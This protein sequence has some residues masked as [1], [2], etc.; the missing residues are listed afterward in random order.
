MKVYIMTDLEG[1]SGA[2][3]DQFMDRSLPWYRDACRFLMGDVNAAIAGAFDGGATEVWARDGHG[4][5]HNFIMDLLDP[6]AIHEQ[7]Y[8][9][10]WYGSLDESFDAA[11]F[12][13]AHAMAGT[14]TAFLD[15]TQSSRA[16]FEFKVNGR[17]MGEQGQWG[18]GCGHFDIPVVLVTGD[19]AACAEAR[20]FF[21]G[22]QTVAVKR[23]VCRNRASCYPVEKAQQQ[24]R[25][26]AAAALKNVAAVKPMKVD[27]PIVCEQTYYRTDMADGAERGGK[28]RIGPRTVRKTVEKQTDVVM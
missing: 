13:G 3:C 10:G 7:R 11:F 23:A 12:V 5:G 24:I 8:F 4:T 18:L 26:A 19:E 6:R 28:E 9:G 21:P 14:Q 1:V 16:I 27:A 22:C 25:A 17:P 2:A 20:E 15:H